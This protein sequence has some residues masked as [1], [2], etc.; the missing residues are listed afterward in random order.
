MNR[1]LRIIELFAGLGAPRIALD[2]LNIKYESAL[3]VEN[4][5][6]VI[7]M[8]N[9]IHSTNHEPID[10]LELNEFPQGIDYLHASPP[11]QAFS[12]Q[13]KQLGASDSRGER[14]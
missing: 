7:D 5:K 4:D 2:N 11:R 12:S 1:P 10:I 8:Y 14:L 3:V 9:I 6:H 13:G